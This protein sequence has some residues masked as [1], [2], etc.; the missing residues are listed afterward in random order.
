MCCLYIRILIYK[1]RKAIPTE[2]DQLNL[3]N[4]T[5]VQKTGVNTSLSKSFLFVHRVSDINEVQISPYS[6]YSLNR[7]RKERLTLDS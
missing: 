5:A 4:T 1:H 7:E 3:S 6:L 2:L